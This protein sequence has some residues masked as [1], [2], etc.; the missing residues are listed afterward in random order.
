M[1]HKLINTFVDPDTLPLEQESHD[2][3]SRPGSITN[4]LYDFREFTK[5]PHISWMTF[6]L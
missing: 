2:P 1:R 3:G 6:C 5:T 4:Q